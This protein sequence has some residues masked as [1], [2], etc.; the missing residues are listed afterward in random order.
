[1]NLKR[2]CL[3]FCTI[4]SLC[5]AICCCGNIGPPR[6]P[7]KTL[8]SPV[9][10][11]K[12][13]LLCDKIVLT[14]T[15]PFTNTDGTVLNTVE[16][17]D[18][19]RSIQLPSSDTG[20]SKTGE[21]EKPQA[22]ESGY[23]KEDS[24]I[25][26]DE[27]DVNRNDETTQPESSMK[28]EENTDLEGIQDD[29]DPDQK[30]FENQ[31]S[32]KSKYFNLNRKKIFSFDK[33]QIREILKIRDTFQY[34][35]DG[36]DLT[37]EIISESDRE[38]RF[39]NGYRYQYSLEVYGK[40]KQVNRTSKIE[41]VTFVLVPAQVQ[42]LTVKAIGPKAYLSWDPVSTDCNGDE[43][44]NFTGYNVYRSTS[45][46]SF[47]DK[48]VNSEPLEESIF[49]DEKI[50]FDTEYY[51]IVRAQVKTA[52][53]ESDNSKPVSIFISDI[54]PPAPPIG[55]TLIKAVDR[56]NLV[57]KPNEELDVAGYNIYRSELPGRGYVK[58]NDVLIER[59]FFSDMSIK[60]GITYYYV[61]TSV[62][63][64]EIPNESSYSTEISA[65][66]R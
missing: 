11:L 32:K 58:I 60:K 4:I 21:S 61:I 26:S 25:P 3:K 37:K 62:D 23:L 47:L 9:S 17:L 5:T 15:R 39:F 41:T 19:F 34:I 53:M 63:Q 24:Q 55:F 7:R 10:D 1:M 12:G 64:A 6:I 22:K 8:P 65:T 35:D 27:S 30:I 50:Q 46:D 51:Y 13:K 40:G 18:L 36:E 14:W 45:P 38:H 56:I 42:N 52:A 59:S 33:K 54:F 31:L 43:I 44:N 66:I 2:N 20:K 48:P 28:N 57:W 49:I 29:S 16:R